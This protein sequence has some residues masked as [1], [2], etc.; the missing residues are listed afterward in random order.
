[1]AR[2][3]AGNTFE[4]GLAMDFNPI[5]TPNNVMTSALN[6]TIITF[7]GN[8]YILQTD[9]GNG[10]V[11]TAYLPAGYVPVGMVEF[12]GVIYVASY[13]PFLNRGQMGSFPSPERNISTDEMSDIQVS[14]I[15]GDFG[16]DEKN[17]DKGA[18][19]LYVQKTLYSKKL[20]PGDKFIVYTPIGQTQTNIENNRLFDGY[21]DHSNAYVRGGGYTADTPSGNPLDTKSVELYFATITDEGKIARLPRLRDYKYDNDDNK[22]Y[23]IPEME[24]NPDGT[25]DVDSYRS[26]IESPF[27]VFNS[28]VSGE[29]LLIAELVTVD[30]FSVSVICEFNDQ[31][32]AEASSTLR[33][34]AITVE[35]QFESDN[36]VYLYA[37]TADITDTNAE[38]AST[39]TNSHLMWEA[40]TVVENDGEQVL[41]NRHDEA[42][43]TTIE[44]YDVEKREERSIAY[45]ITPCMTWGSI[46]YLARSGVIQLDKVGSGFIELYEWRYF[47]NEDSIILGW[48]LQAYPEEGYSI[49]GV[50]FIMSCL[51][52]NGK[53]Q[54]IIYNVSK[55]NSY[56]GSFSE[57]IPLNSEYYKIEVGD[58]D[59][60]SQPVLLPDRLY[61]VTIEVQYCKGGDVTDTSKFQYFYRWLYTTNTFNAEYREGKIVDFRPLKPTV[62]FGIN[63]SLEANAAEAETVTSYSETMLSTS[64]GLSQYQYALKQYANKYNITGNAELAIINMEG[65]LKLSEGSCK[66]TASVTNEDMTKTISTQDVSTLGDGVAFGLEEK[67]TIRIRENSERDPF[68]PVLPPEGEKPTEGELPEEWDFSSDMYQ[69]D[70][71]LVT[72]ED[73]FTK[74]GTTTLEITAGELVVETLEYAKLVAYMAD[75]QS[76]QYQCLVEPCCVTEDDYLNYTLKFNSETKKFNGT[77]LPGMNNP[78]YGRKGNRPALSWTLIPENGNDGEAPKYWSGKHTEDMSFVTKDRLSFYNETTYSKDRGQAF[79]G[80]LKYPM[81]ALAICASGDPEGENDGDVGMSVSPNTNTSTWD[82]TTLYKDDNWWIDRNNPQKQ[83]L[84]NTSNPIYSPQ[85]LNSEKGKASIA[86]TKL[87]KKWGALMDI[88]VTYVT[89]LRLASDHDLAVPINMFTPLTPKSIGQAQTKPYEFIH[90]NYMAQMLSQLYV[91]DNEG[92]VLTGVTKPVVIAYTDRIITDFTVSIKFTVDPTGFTTEILLDDGVTSE[93]SAIIDSVYRENMWARNHEEVLNQEKDVMPTLDLIPDEENNI[94]FDI[95]DEATEVIATCLIQNTRNI[96]DV[97]NSVAQYLEG[98][99]QTLIMN[100]DQTTNFS[101][102]RGETGKVYY[103]VHSE[104]TDEYVPT[105]L[106]NGFYLYDVVFE[107]REK[108]TGEKYYVPSINPNNPEPI[109]TIGAFNNMLVSEGKYIYLNDVNEN[110]VMSLKANRIINLSIN[111]RGGGKYENTAWNGYSLFAPIKLLKALDKKYVPL[112]R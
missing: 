9:M 97:V 91:C 99:M 72:P 25:P 2:K 7:N 37:V 57:T 4:K 48:A 52:R 82:Y 98:T 75:N 32:G 27:N 69:N 110:S 109:S 6:A 13:S 17:P 43:L 41:D 19:T 33:D 60:D 22:R 70:M 39:K 78:D 3:I 93:I 106:N 34:V 111:G 104:E 83:P 38:G 108:T 46:T 81:F 45:T 85:V 65:L 88:G 68:I 55:K 58:G 50:R 29:L 20:S 49:A 77:V 67:A 63:S 1:M 74:E 54:T 80:L 89:M 5:S 40:A 11:E 84:A 66:M 31:E 95:P 103:I 112:I 30:S 101:S 107:E 42:L 16:F 64:G 71:R 10:R 12:G 86:W 56:S 47:R 15:N 105:V 73:E 87:D 26:L 53:V 102:I 14:L 94:Q 61:Y 23:I 92:G 100:P 28:K 36:D 96:Q 35:M 90:F 59:T 24:D 79:I 51:A 76:V 62:E 8:E 18:S 44:G 21:I